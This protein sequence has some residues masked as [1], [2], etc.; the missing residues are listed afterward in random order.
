MNS[1]GLLS[2]LFLWAPLLLCLATNTGEDVCVQVGPS[3]L[4]LDGSGDAEGADGDAAHLGLLQRRAMKQMAVASD[5]GSA[6]QQQQQQQQ[7]QRQQ[8]QQQQQ[9]K[10]AKG[11]SPIAWCTSGGGWLAMAGGMGFAN[12]FQKAGLFEADE[13][14]NI[15]SNS[16]G[17]WFLTQFAYNANFHANVT[18]FSPTELAGMVQS[19]VGAYEG[20]VPEDASSNALLSAFGKATAA[21]PILAEMVSAAGAGTAYDFDWGAMIS[22][23]I[24]RTP[25]L[26]S[27][28]FYQDIVADQKSRPVLKRPTLHF[29][30]AQL[31]AA[32]LPYEL[33]LDKN[34][35][36][37]GQDGTPLIQQG[38]GLPA[39]PLQYIVPGEAASQTQAEAPSEA[40]LAMP[41]SSLYEYQAVEIGRVDS[42]FPHSGLPQKSWE[43]RKEN[44]PQITG[45]MSVADVAV[46]SSAAAGALGSQEITQEVMTK[47]IGELAYEA[48]KDGLPYGMGGL[49]VCSHP[50]DNGQCTYPAIKFVDGGYVDN[51]ATAQT[52]AYMQQQFGTDQRLRMVLTDN[53]NMP[54]G[55]AAQMT[56][57]SF[58]MDRGSSTMPGYILQESAYAYGTSMPSQQVFAASFDG[59]QWADIAGSEANMYYSLKWANV[60]TQTVDN[61]AYGVQAGTTVDLLIFALAS[62]LS[63]FQAGFS[64]QYAEVASKLA[65]SETSSI[66]KQWL[67]GSS[68]SGVR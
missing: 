13:L 50:L 56:D 16:G 49:A 48:I 31:N 44:A 32:L 3:G 43:W 26:S 8:Q 47:A 14:S 68:T 33:G 34:A 65:R 42:I 67:S 53:E 52:A 62:E 24:S 6:S 46:V 38:G 10:T 61:P 5:I 22:D 17:S 40:G 28:T 63:S 19:L 2:L 18:T 57:I 4:C 27:K 59:L 36:L 12:S 15:A 45:Q 21:T 9:A 37:L 55:R 20:V 30:T 60:T 35:Y 23:M 58:L 64:P 51:L 39:S 25:G 1:I 29:Q 54:K 7:Q 11:E 41:S 66:V